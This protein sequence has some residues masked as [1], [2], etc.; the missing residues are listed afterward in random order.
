MWLTKKLIGSLF[1][2]AIAHIVE[3]DDLWVR[4]WLSWHICNI[5]TQPRTTD[6]HVTIVIAYTYV[7]QSIHGPSSRC[8]FLYSTMAIFVRNVLHQW[9]RLISFA[10]GLLT[11]FHFICVAFLLPLPRYYVCWW[12][13]WYMD[14]VSVLCFLTSAWPAQLETNYVECY[15]W[16]LGLVTSGVALLTLFKSYDM[17][18]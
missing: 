15:H 7:E 18:K 14:V 4:V 10:H 1:S 12:R 8:R 17:A 5:Q 6:M 3:P 13:V 2:R 11:G 9:P 16:L